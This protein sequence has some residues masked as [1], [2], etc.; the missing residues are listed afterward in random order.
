MTVACGFFS[1]GIYCGDPG[2]GTRVF[3]YAGDEYHFGDTV[4]YLCPDGYVDKELNTP[5]VTSTCSADGSWQPA[6]AVCES[7]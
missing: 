5:A 3:R 7:R 6:A 4:V 2:N 1:A